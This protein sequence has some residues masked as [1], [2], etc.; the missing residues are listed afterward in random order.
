MPLNRMPIENITTVLVNTA[1][2]VTLGV[3]IS[4]TGLPLQWHVC[5]SEMLHATDAIS[6]GTFIATPRQWQFI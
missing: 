3:N 4:W 2:D 5:R 6:L 1:H